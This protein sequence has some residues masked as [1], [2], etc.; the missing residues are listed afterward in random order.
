DHRS[1][2]LMTQRLQRHP[3]LALFDGPDTNVTTDV[4]GTSTVPLQ[5]LFLMNNPFV[6]AQAEGL[7]RRLASASAA[8]ARRFPLGCELPW[9]RP[10]SP[11]ETAAALDYLDCCGRELAR[12][13]APEASRDHEAWTSLARVLLGS[14][15]FA[16]VD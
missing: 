6:R 5:A 16:Y 8:S 13:G 2:Y 3:F 4:R 10:P 12:A 9:G 11:E 15:E 7:A 14:N 1:V